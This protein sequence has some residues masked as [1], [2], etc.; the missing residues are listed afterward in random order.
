MIYLHFEREIGECVS[1]SGSYASL[2]AL[3]D[4]SL[5]NL[6]TY[7]MTQKNRVVAVP[8]NLEHHSRVKTSI[9]Q[10]QVLENGKGVDVAKQL[11]SSKIEG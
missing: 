5:R 6:D 8:R 2:D 11:V 4:L 9:A 1:K 10:Y 7:I 3:I